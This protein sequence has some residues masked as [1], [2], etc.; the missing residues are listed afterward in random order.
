MSSPLEGGSKISSGLD[1]IP[2]NEAYFCEK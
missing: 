2:G 1:G